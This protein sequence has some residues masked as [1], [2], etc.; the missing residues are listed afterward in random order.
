MAPTDRHILAGS[1]AVLAVLLAGAPKA[2][3]ASATWSGATSDLWS[4]GANWSATPVPGTTDTATFNSA[5]ANTTISLGAGVTIQTLL[6]DTSSATANHT[7]T[8]AGAISGSSGAGVK[9]LTI[10]GVGRT[11]VSGLISDGS[12]GSLRLTK[13]GTGILTLS[14]ANTFTGKTTLSGGTLSINSLGNVGAASSAL[15]A[16]TTVADGTIDFTTA[17]S[18]LVYTGPATSSDRVL[19]FASSSGFRVGEVRASPGRIKSGCDS[20]RNFGNLWRQL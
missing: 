6:Y 7:L 10:G 12:G 5:S 19:N 18:T 3:S 2:R 4:T 8:L 13:T 20:F 15:G 9:T 11:T 14:G 17:S 16:P 1:I